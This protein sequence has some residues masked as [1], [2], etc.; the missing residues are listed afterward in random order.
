M[1]KRKVYPPEFKREAVAMTQ[2]PNAV[3]EEVARN[4][5]VSSSAL[6]KWIRAEKAGGALAFP[7]QGKQALSA[8]QA[9]IQRLRKENEQLRME[10]EI[11]KKAT[12]FFA[13]ES[14]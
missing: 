8:E 3:V 10:R 7:G 6:H 9:E 2:L 4:L 11:L 1:K 5:G 12:A 14:E 13:K